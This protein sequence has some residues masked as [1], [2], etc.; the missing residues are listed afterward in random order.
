MS[1]SVTLILGDCLAH[2]PIE[3]DAVISDPPY[4]IGYVHGGGAK[5]KRFNGGTLRGS[6]SQPIIGDNAPFDPAPW[7]QY[8]LVVLWGANHYASRL[9]DSS[10]WLGWD[11]HLQ[12]IGNSFSE[13]EFAWTNSRGKKAHLFR[14][15]WNGGFRCGEARATSSIHPT[16]KPV[17]L[18][19]WC[20]RKMKVPEGA[21]VLDPYMGSG[22]T[23][24][25]CIRTGRKFIGIERD[26]VHF[27]TA[28]KRISAELE[29]C[30]F[31]L[32]QGRDGGEQQ[33]AFDT[34]PCQT[35]NK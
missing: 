18:M 13:I 23:G 4:G 11:K 21:T 9:P 19:A 32:P 30:V 8:P 2:L 14:F 34:E 29:E 17:E 24:I 26:P 16:Q 35:H 1:D 28:R 12:E 20:M 27:E 7:L 33:Q 15:M 6:K 31:E 22:S 3:A 5:T 10:A 25:A